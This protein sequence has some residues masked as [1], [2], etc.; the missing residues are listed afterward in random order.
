MTL[1][2]FPLSP[3]ELVYQF[4]QNFLSKANPAAN[5]E[6]TKNPNNSSGV[7]RDGKI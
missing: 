2:P 4:R 6:I 5:A 3:H 1:L 7:A